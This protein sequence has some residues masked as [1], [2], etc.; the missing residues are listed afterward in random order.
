MRTDAHLYDELK[1]LKKDLARVTHLLLP[2]SFKAIIL[3][4]HCEEVIS[5]TKQ[6]ISNQFPGLDCFVAASPLLAMTVVPLTKYLWVIVRVTQ[7]RDLLEKAA[8]YFAKESQ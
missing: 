7:E 8:A 3:I 1:R 2:T 5:Y 6:S 4:H